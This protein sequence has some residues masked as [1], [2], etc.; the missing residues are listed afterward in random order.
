MYFALR[1]QLWCLTVTPYWVVVTVSKYSPHQAKPPPEIM[2][3]PT[4]P[5]A[6]IS[7]YFRKDLETAMVT[8][9]PERLL[10][11]GQQARDPS[12]SSEGSME[13]GKRSVQGWQIL[14]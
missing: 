3:V 13:P 14:V 4:T 6:T 12:D 1:S 5:P 10:I 7:I 8:P 9:S 2:K 11:Q